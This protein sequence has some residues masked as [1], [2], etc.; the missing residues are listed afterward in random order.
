MI[1]SEFWEANSINIQWT[2]SKEGLSQGW[3]CTRNN[4][5]QDRLYSMGAIRLFNKNQSIKSKAPSVFHSCKC[6]ESTPDTSVNVSQCYIKE[7]CWKGTYS[8]FWLEPVS[9][10]YFGP[11]SPSKTTVF[12]FQ[13]GVIWVPLQ[14]K[15]L[16]PKCTQSSLLANV[17]SS[18]TAW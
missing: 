8:D 4:S 14:V 17:S 7:P 15:S 16:S 5:L 11:I 18:K 9:L 1:S 2:C 6:N 12:P 3:K 13:T 10:L